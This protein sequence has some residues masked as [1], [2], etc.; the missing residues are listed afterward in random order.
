[1]YT[2]QQLLHVPGIDLHQKDVYGV[3]LLHRLC[4]QNLVSYIRIL[5]ATLRK[6]HMDPFCCDLSLLTPLHYAAGRNMKEAVALLIKEGA[7]V[8]AKDN[9]GNT[10]LHLAAVTGSC[11]VISLLVQA[12][13]NLSSE[14]RFGWIA[15]DQ[16]SI[17]QKHNA[18]KL[19]LSLGSPLPSWEKRKYAL[20]E[21]VRLSPCP[22]DCYIYHTALS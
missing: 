12:G 6:L 9:H 1:M 5:V 18:V 11:E 3:T 8:S 4:A 10:P 21:F 17:S 19:L 15:I 13:A 16:A 7:D 14:A 22:L 2:F 20:S